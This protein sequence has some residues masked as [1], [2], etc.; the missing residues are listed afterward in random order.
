MRLLIQFNHEYEIKIDEYDE[1]EIITL[2]AFFEPIDLD[3]S[4]KGKDK[5]SR[6]QD[7]YWEYLDVRLIFIFSIKLFFLSS[8]KSESL[9]FLKQWKK[10]FKDYQNFKSTDFKQFI[11][12]DINNIELGKPWYLIEELGFWI[13]IDQYYRLCL[14]HRFR[15]HQKT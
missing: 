14:H 11:P 10:P 9:K 12:P 4:S 1:N 6:S 13:G 2:N 8:K 3:V 7:N 15:L 5:N